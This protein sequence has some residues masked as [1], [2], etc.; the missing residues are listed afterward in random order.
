MSVTYKT[1]K[2]IALLILVVG[3]PLYVIFAVSVM[4]NIDRLPK[5]LELPVYVFLGVAWALPFRWV[6]LGIGKEDPDNEQG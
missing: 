5:W 6:F 2:R 1:R 4:S 3:M